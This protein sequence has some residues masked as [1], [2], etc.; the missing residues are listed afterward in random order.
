MLYEQPKNILEMKINETLKT[1]EESIVTDLIKI[2]LMKTAEKDESLLI[3]TEIFNLLGL[4]KFTELISLIDGKTI[5][6]PTKENFKD[7]VITTLCYYYKNIEN[8]DW[9]E[10]KS[11]LG[12]PDLNGVKYGI[13]S[14][15]LE[16]FINQLIKKRLS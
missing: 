15:Q 14:S 10:I 2:S 6:F 12:M 13:K 16:T 5:T 4:E 1:S 7:T 9:N 3:F 8:L 11:N